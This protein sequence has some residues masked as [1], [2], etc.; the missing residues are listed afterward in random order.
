MA[1][2]LKLYLLVTGIG[3]LIA[4]AVPDMATEG[5]LLFFTSVIAMPMPTA[6]L[7]G[8]VFAALWYPLQFWLG[9][10][11]ATMFA[12][13]AAIG[14]LYV[15]AIPSHRASRARLAEP[16][17]ADI[18]PR[19]PLVIAGHVRLDVPS[20]A[21]EQSDPSNPIAPLRAGC[22]GLCAAMLFT[23][24]VES[25]TV[26]PNEKRIVTRGAAI[27]DTP[28]DSMA[29]TFRRVPVAQCGKTVRPAG[30]GLK[31]GHDEVDPLRSSWNL[32]LSTSDCIITDPPREQYD[33]V[34]TLGMY[35]LFGDSYYSN[36]WSLGARAVDIARFQIRRA[37]G[38]VLLR[39]SI[40]STQELTRPLQV[41]AYGGPLGGY[42]GLERFGWSHTLLISPDRNV[43]LGTQGLLV[44]RLLKKHT[45]LVLSADP[46]A[47]ARLARDRLQ[48][49]VDDPAVTATDTGWL[50]AEG[51]LA[52]LRETSIDDADRRLLPALIRDRRMTGFGDFWEVVRA[53][54]GQGTILREAM[55]ERLAA[56][57]A[58]QELNAQR[59]LAR[60]IILLPPE[61]FASPSPAE[62]HLL[63][64]PALRSRLPG[65]VARQA[66][67]GAA[68][69][70]LLL[71]IIEYH[72]RAW[73]RSRN[74][75]S[76]PPE[77]G[78]NGDATMIDAVRVAFCRLGPAGASALPRLMALDRVREGSRLP[79][80]D[81]ERAL[82][83][84]RLGQPVESFAKPGYVDGTTE[85]FH[86]TLHR[87]LAHFRPDEDCRVNFVTT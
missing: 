7:Y 19:R 23:P 2:L 71:D 40:A 84:A 13:P 34:V 85:D 1:H 70:P 62:L 45:N 80:D 44:E 31:T 25:V 16:M 38:T 83:L 55:I 36:G 78:T 68:A 58:D 21:T 66:D 18:T 65:L 59:A 29:R 5:L 30:G 10:Q 81:V 46:V 14:L 50:V 72:S 73:V 43:E 82:T 3:T 6:F 41:S 52:Q 57:G 47:I 39:A 32:R 87:G 79:W 77:P 53:L 49:M 56:P 76:H 12:L 54:G 26:N 37:D 11:R 61:T 63:N 74:D 69:V 67:R 15:A 60:A 8:C 75:R 22:D 35:G 33:L 9:P 64:D 51:Y 24:G 27:G 42:G 86:A 28:L 20:F 48:A 17:L 4:I